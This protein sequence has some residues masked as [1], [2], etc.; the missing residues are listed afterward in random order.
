MMKIGIAG[1]VIMSEK[2]K[3]FEMAFEEDG[4]G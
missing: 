1:R 4:K 3:R 2:E